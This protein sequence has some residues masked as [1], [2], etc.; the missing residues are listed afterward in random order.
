MEEDRIRIDPTTNLNQSRYPA[1]TDLQYPVLEETANSILTNTPWIYDS[2]LAAGYERWFEVCWYLVSVFV[3][4]NW[5]YQ[6]SFIIHL[7]LHT[8]GYVSI[9]T[10]ISR[11]YYEIGFTLIS[12]MTI[13][14]PQIGMEHWLY[15]GFKVGE[16]Y[17]FTYTTYNPIM[18]VSVDE[19][20]KRSQAN[21]SK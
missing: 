2:A 6:I 15:D 16:P 9:T 21:A 14:F 17:T 3:E 13:S 8:Q 11:M 5:K 10:L 4:L 18:G 7:K 12:D 1:N 20:S 19:F